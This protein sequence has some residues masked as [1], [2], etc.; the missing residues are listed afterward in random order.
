MAV[1]RSA[2]GPA[3]PGRRSWLRTRRRETRLGRPPWKNTPAYAALAGLLMVGGSEAAGTAIDHRETA[4]PRPSG[5]EFGADGGSPLFLEP[6]PGFA[7]G[8]PAPPRTPGRHTAPGLPLPLVSGVPQSVL[9]A[10]RAAAGEVARTD[11]GCRL[12]VALL[13]AIGR[14]ESSHAW[15]GHVDAAGTT[16]SPILGPRLDGSAGTAAIGDTDDGA[17]DSD[18]TWDRAVGPMQFIPSTWTSWAV[19]AN[20][21]GIASP[22]NVND[23]ALAAG[24]YLCADGRDLSTQDGLHSAI[25]SYNHSGEYLSV[26]L[27]WMR[28]Y[29]GSVVALPD[30][31]GFDRSPPAEPAPRNRPRERR[32]E[33]QRQPQPEERPRESRPEEPAA[34]PAPRPSPEASRDRELIQVPEPPRDGSEA[35][36]ETRRKVRDGLHDTVDTADDVG[37]TLNTG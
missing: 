3:R 32:E 25:L 12:S 14:V 22:H 9:D 8:A 20:G 29:A 2:G 24:R 33:P 6:P 10:Y 27:G 37:E 18:S 30:D 16:L 1:R 17:Y 19:D 23:A 34:E 28:I 5:V 26:V 15:G 11:P 35:V 36:Q 13:A 21:D 31:G 4:S 7:G